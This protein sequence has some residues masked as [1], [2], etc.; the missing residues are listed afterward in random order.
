MGKTVNDASPLP[1]YVQL[2]AC[3]RERI[4]SG[5]FREGSCI[6]SE[7]SL[8]KQY[9]VSRITVR[10]AVDGLV[11][12]GLLVKR[13]GIGTWVTQRRF[14]DDM[15]HLKSFS[16]KTR[17]QHVSTETQV[18]ETGYVAAEA[19]I[20]G[21]LGEETGSMVFRVKRLRFIDGEPITILTSFF[22]VSLGMG[23]DCDFSGSVYQILEDTGIRI[24]HAE[25]SIEA[26]KAG[27]DESH[28][29]GIQPGDA[30]LLISSA[31]RDITGRVV[32]YAQGLYRGDRYRYLLRV[33]RHQAESCI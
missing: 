24:D 2:Q 32:E 14:I 6:P 10:G 25:R 20:A 26:V 33:N 17:E 9:S 1:L 22:P 16:E 28:L 27:N 18:L 30:L 7:T 29:L 3:I 23:N 12:E 13:Q 8:Q 4:A 19:E 21:Y 11:N 5:E 31:T 15:S